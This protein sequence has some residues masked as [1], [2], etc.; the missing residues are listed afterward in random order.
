MRVIR[1]IGILFAIGIV[2]TFSATA[3]YWPKPAKTPGVDVP[4][5]G[6]LE[7]H[8]NKLTPGYPASIQT[9]VGRFLDS[10]ATQDYQQPFKTARAETVL[11]MPALHRIYFQIGSA[12]FAYNLD[13]FF[14]RLASG[15]ALM[16]VN[17]I[18]SPAPSANWP[19]HPFPVD[20]V[21]AYDAFFY[22]ENQPTGW[23]YAT[24]DGQRRL[25]QFDVDD[26]GYVYLAYSVFGWGIVK[27]DLTNPNSHTL[28]Q[29]LHQDRN[30][31]VGALAIAVVKT[32]AG[33]YYAV[34]NGGGALSNVYDVTD[35]ANP[36]KRASLPQIATTSAKNAA[37]DRIAFSGDGR[38]TIYT[39]DAIANGGSPLLQYFGSGNVSS[40][41]CDGTNFYATGDSPSGLVLSVFSPAGNSYNR[42]DYRFPNGTSVATTHMRWGDGYLVWAGSTNGSSSL[43]FF[44][45]SNGVPTE[46]DFGRYFQNYYFGVPNDSRYTAPNFGYLFDSTIVKKDTHTYIVATVYSLGDVYEIPSS[47]S[48]VVNNL[49]VGGT[50]NSPPVRAPDAG[51]GPFYGDPVKFKAITGATSPLNVI[52]DFGNPEAS[53]AADP[54]TSTGTTGVEVSHRYSGLTSATSLPIT[55]SVKATNALDTSINSTTSVTIQKPTVRFGVGNY[56]YLFMQPNASSPAP[57]VLGDQFFDSSD[58]TV[59]SHYNTWSI[60]GAT[61][62][63]TVPPAQVDVG[64]CGVHNL[65]FDAHYGPYTPNPIAS[66]GA[67][68]PIGIHGSGFDFK[69]TV[70]P[71]AAAIDVISDSTNVSFKSLARASAIANAISPPQLL[72]LTYRWELVEAASSA[73]AFPGPTGTGLPA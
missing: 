7:Q 63:R 14:S 23:E 2:S 71:F 16:S 30:G 29:S 4:C 11:V 48:V 44:K 15:E 56:K 64:T 39:A 19:P 51:A 45:V 61:A 69:Y 65:S 22:V 17:A 20:L 35:R 66:L 28:M 5:T 54:N 68:M 58:G 38:V 21:L 36:I 31:D 18:P 47:D 24:S 6:C 46:M 52:W 27:D 10:Q 60:D 40:V 1:N 25:F 26:Q 32:S 43:R 55:R 53:P 42:T 3:Q 12:V 41:A 70:V 33:R 59:Q 72:G 62:Y 9:F 8:N 34:I 37:M 67:D 49:G 57:I 13:T 73:Q 50:A